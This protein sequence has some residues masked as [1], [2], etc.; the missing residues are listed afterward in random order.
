MKRARLNW[1]PAKVGCSWSTREFCIS[2][3][4]T[5]RNGR[6]VLTYP[7]SGYVLVRIPGEEIGL[8]KTLRAAQLAAERIAAH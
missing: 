7:D 2:T 6:A 8:Y 4:V 5:V 3:R 1:T